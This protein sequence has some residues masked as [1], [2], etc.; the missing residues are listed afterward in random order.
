MAEFKTTEVTVI[1]A[2]GKPFQRK[3]TLA[4]DGLV[5]SVALRDPGPGGRNWIPTSKGTGFTRTQFRMSVHISMITEEGPGFDLVTLEGQIKDFKGND[6]RQSMFNTF[7]QQIRD[8]KGNILKS[9]AGDAFYDYAINHTFET[10]V[11]HE[12]ER[13][14]TEMAEVG[15]IRTVDAQ[16][17]MTELNMKILSMIDEQESNRPAAAVKPAHL[18]LAPNAIL[19]SSMNQ[20]ASSADIPLPL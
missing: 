14:K 7:A 4:A 3:G 17:G 8:N 9:K 15:H 16:R 20:F 11:E 18:Q 2:S 10:I 12:I 19:S 5:V 13:V 1:S 6:G